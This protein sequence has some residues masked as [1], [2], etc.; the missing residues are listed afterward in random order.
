MEEKIIGTLGA[1]A[2]VIGLIMFVRALAFKLSGTETLGRVLSSRPDGKGR[3]LHKITY[4]AG[5]REIVSED[6][7]G[8]SQSMESGTDLLITFKKN[9][10]ESFKTAQ[11]LR[12]GLIGFGL[13]ALMGGAFVVR[14]LII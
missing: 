10:P 3:Y 7:T 12:M 14:F 1:A 6:K 11:E 4:Q 13:L 9:E 8:Y 5:G 2:G